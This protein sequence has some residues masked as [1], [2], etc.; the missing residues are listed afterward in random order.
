MVPLTGKCLPLSEAVF[1][2]FEPVAYFCV[3]VMML[4]SIYNAFF[5]G[6][7]HIYMVFHLYA[8]KLL[9]FMFLCM[10]LLTILNLGI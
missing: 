6:I 9:I 2:S 3:L 5:L 4:L 7:F 10:L 1:M 8:Q